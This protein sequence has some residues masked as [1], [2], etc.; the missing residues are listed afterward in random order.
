MKVFK[1]NFIKILFKDPA[2]LN[3]DFYERPSFGGHQ[4]LRQIN[5]MAQRM[6][7]MTHDFPYHLNLEIIQIS[8]T[9]TMLDHFAFQTGVTKVQSFLGRIQCCTHT[10]TVGYP[11][12]NSSNP[13]AKIWL[14]RN[15]CWAAFLGYILF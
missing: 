14:S 11:S 9:H 15:F 1:R 2:I 3:Q 8:S 12:K 10:H 13:N 6:N 5:A 7:C 4:V